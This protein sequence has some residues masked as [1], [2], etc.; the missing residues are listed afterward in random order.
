MYLSYVRKSTRGLSINSFW[1]DFIGGTLSE[2]QI[3]FD[4]MLTGKGGFWE[5]LNIT[6]F[7]LGLVT[8]SYDLICFFQHYVLYKNSGKKQDTA[9]PE[10]ATNLEEIISKGTLPQTID[11]DIQSK[12]S[13]N[14]KWSIKQY[15]DKKKPNKEQDEENISERNSK[16]DT[17]EFDVAKYA[18][19]KT[20]KDSEGETAD[21]DTISEN[22]TRK[23]SEDLK[24]SKYMLP[25]NSNREQTDYEKVDQKNEKITIDLTNVQ[26]EKQIENNIEKN[27][28]NSNV[29]DKKID[30]YFE[31]KNFDNTIEDKQIDSTIEEKHFDN[32]D[33]EDQIASKIEQKQIESN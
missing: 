11:L 17:Q 27:P 1:G 9:K 28:I 21:Y 26:E 8:I 31:E 6:K 16:N 30:S 18:L 23:K 32:K 22:V 4:W 24:T 12:P 33:E 15:I 19:P 25:K 5:E 10:T 29:E 14:N 20:P 2:C 7:L 13:D 3:V